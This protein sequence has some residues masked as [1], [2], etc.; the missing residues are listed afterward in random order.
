MPLSE[1]PSLNEQLTAIRNE[2]RL[3]FQRE[4]VASTITSKDTTEVTGT[5]TDVGTDQRATDTSVSS[6][7]SDANDIR[8]QIS[9]LLMKSAPKE[10]KPKG[11]FRRKCIYAFILY[12]YCIHKS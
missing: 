12:V 1:G 6:S 4:R 10:K 8:T 2:Q 5:D 11:M 3:K 7:H 9:N